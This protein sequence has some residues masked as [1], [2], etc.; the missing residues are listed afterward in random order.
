MDEEADGI[1]KTT[2]DVVVVVDS[3]FDSITPRPSSGNNTLQKAVMKFVESKPQ[4]ELAPIM[5]QVG[6][7]SGG[8]GSS[9][10][11]RIHPGANL[12]LVPNF[13][14]SP[15][16]RRRRKKSSPVCCALTTFAVLL[17]AFL[18]AFPYL[19]STF[20]SLVNLPSI[21]SKVNRGSVSGVN[22]DDLADPPSEKVA[23]KKDGDIDSRDPPSPIW[24][25][26][27]DD[28]VSYYHQ[29]AASPTA[30][31]HHLVLLH[32]SAFTK[33]DWKTSGILGLFHR[34]FPAVTVT[35][36]DLPVSADHGA[37]ARLMRSMRDEDLIEQLPISA[38]VT[39]SA[40]GYSITSWIREESSEGLSSYVS[41]WIPVASY[42][43]AQCSPGDL[44]TLR[45]QRPDVSVL[46]I[47][48][49]RDKQGGT[50]MESLREHSGAEVLEL[51]GRHPVYLDSPSEFVEAVGNAV[52]AIE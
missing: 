39:P 31:N 48:G 32:G 25:T 27:G 4:Q 26:V 8:G 20:D 41:A 44:E 13:S 5:T 19:L 12:S 30:R 6:G 52:L 35:A 43:V 34:E 14:F 51:P 23:A 10:S 9:R 46:A 7:S 33:E 3:V 42:S 47:Y 28:N 40:S 11:R 37:L 45:A 38:L 21:Q 49:D 50:V 1:C 16:K 18:V 17:V 24:G 2:D 22:D 15:G 29:P 36:L